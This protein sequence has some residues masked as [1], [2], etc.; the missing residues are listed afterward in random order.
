MSEFKCHFDWYP[1]GAL[2]AADRG[3][4]VIIVDVLSFS[5]SVAYAVSN[6]AIII[7]C[8]HPNMAEEI[9]F[10][11][12]AVISVSRPDVSSKGKYSLSPATFLDIK[13]GERV[14]LVSPNGARCCLN[15]NGA[16]KVI[17]GGLVNAQAIADYVAEFMKIFEKSV[18]V[19][20]CGER[21]YGSYDGILRRAEEDYLGA[22]AII[23]QLQC[24]KTNEALLCE[25]CF[26]E[27]QK[28]FK[29]EISNCQ[30]GIELRELGYNKDIKLAIELNC[31]KVVPVYENGIIIS[32]D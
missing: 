20:A 6:R 26:I 32:N 16:Y 27:R 3:D 10:R 2:R 18:T 5:T 7:P 19:I 17:I 11:E 21:E 1:E 28:D 31:L 4:I 22:G 23:S 12:K 8:S 25:N 30:S 14:I 24:G 13:A 29:T 15:S 9:A